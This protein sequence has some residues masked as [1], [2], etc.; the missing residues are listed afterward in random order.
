MAQGEGRPPRDGREQRIRHSFPV[1]SQGPTK[2]D[3][4]QRPYRPSRGTTAGSVEA[5]QRPDA[6]ADGSTPQIVPAQTPGNGRPSS[7]P[8]RYVASVRKIYRNGRR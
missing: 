3:L 1:V 6:T 2:R 8:W 5:G 7:A 4:L